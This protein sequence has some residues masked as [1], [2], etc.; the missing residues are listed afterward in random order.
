[1]KAY[2]QLW[3]N[4]S[5][6]LSSRIAK[7]LL[8]QHQHPRGDTREASY[9]GVCYLLYDGLHL[10]RPLT[11]EQGLLARYTKDIP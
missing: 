5:D 11:H 6:I 7:Y 10:F 4:I 3:P 2:L 8:E 9:S 1:M